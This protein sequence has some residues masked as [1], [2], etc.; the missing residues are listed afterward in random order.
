MGSKQADFIIAYFTF[1][2]QN[3]I[4]DEFSTQSTP[5]VKNKQRDVKLS[6]FSQRNQVL[7]IYELCLNCGFSMQWCFNV[8]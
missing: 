3:I 1:N 7:N 4:F 5:I 6:L 8:Y 2:T